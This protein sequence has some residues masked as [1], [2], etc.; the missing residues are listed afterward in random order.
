MDN[1]NTLWCEGIHVEVSDEVY[2]L[3][4]KADRKDRYFSNDL[5]TERIRVDEEKEKITFI[6]SREDSFDRL[7]EENQAQF[8]EDMESV[9]DVALQNVT[10]EELHKAISEITEEEQKLIYALY[11]DNLTEREFADMTG[12]YRNAIHKRKVRILTKLKNILE[13]L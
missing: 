1:N 3:S 8:A 5:K 11:F 13:I 6:P 7:I 9:E 2:E 10:Y 12:V 4:Q